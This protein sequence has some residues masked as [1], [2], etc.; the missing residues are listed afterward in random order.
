MRFWD[1]SAL[2]PLLVTE[3]GTDFALARLEEDPSVAIWALT[4]VELVS[5]IERRWRERRLTAPQRR[6]ALREIVRLCADAHELTE[7]LAVRERAATLLAHDPLR[8]V[9]ACQ[10]AAALMVADANPGAPME[11]VV[12]DRRLAM[13]AD[14]EGLNVLS[15]PEGT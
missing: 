12:L 6:Q 1:S 9:D 5:S 3:P 14:I 4:R 2:L 8:A 7:V 11:F 15:W 10:L 13:A